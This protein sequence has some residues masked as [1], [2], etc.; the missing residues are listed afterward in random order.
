[1]RSST[2]QYGLHSGGCAVR[3]AVLGVNREVLSAP[4]TRLALP[5]EIPPGE[6]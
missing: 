3:G 2:E 4:T 5:T 6:R 1:M